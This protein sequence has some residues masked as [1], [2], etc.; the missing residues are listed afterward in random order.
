MDQFF[1]FFYD[2]AL[3]DLLLE[4]IAFRYP[5]LKLSFSNKDFLSMKGSELDIDLISRNYPIFAKRVGIFISKGPEKDEEGILVGM[6]F[7]NYQILE[8]PTDTYELVEVET[9]IHAPSRAYHKMEQ[10]VRLFDIPLNESEQ[11][12]EIGS[13]PGGISFYLM[14]KGLKLTTIDPAEFDPYVSSHYPNLFQHIKKSVFDVNRKDLPKT[15]DWIVSDLNLAG[16]LNTKQVLRFLKLFPQVKGAFLTI[17]TPD[18]KE[19]KK[20][21]SW[22]HLFKSNSYQVTAFHLPSHRREIGLWVTK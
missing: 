22:I 17:K 2:F 5:K 4:E 18:F 6:D 11:V 19:F 9:P 14:E 13:A 1:L 7:W 3:K 12:I 10:V 21:K 8:S 15:C 20:V 16:D